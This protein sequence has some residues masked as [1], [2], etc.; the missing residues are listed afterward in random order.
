MG[1]HVIRQLCLGGLPLALLIA[2]LLHFVFDSGSWS[3]IFYTI[4]LTA[5]IGYFTNFIAIKMLFR[6]YYPTVMRRQGLIPK[7]QAKLAATLSKTLSHHFLASEHWQ[8]YLEKADIVP[9]ILFSTKNY[10]ETWFEN[11]QNI[12]KLTDTI[13]DYLNQNNV[14]FRQLFEQFQTQV[15]EQ[16]S[17]D[18]EVDELLNQGFDWIEK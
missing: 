5:N 15:I 11:P 18:I 16:I 8:E 3:E 6:P 9:K 7:N 2:F 4:T 14:Q 10:C 13:C 17:E 12:K 1:L